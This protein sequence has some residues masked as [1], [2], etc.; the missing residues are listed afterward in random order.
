[1]LRDG[2]NEFSVDECQAPKSIGEGICDN[3]PHKLM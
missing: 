1:M 2:V 3:R